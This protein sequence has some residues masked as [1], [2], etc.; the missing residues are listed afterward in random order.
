LPGAATQVYVIYYD[1]EAFDKAPGTIVGSVEAHNGELSLDTLERL[2]QGKIPWGQP[3]VVGLRQGYVT[4]P[5]RA[6]AWVNTVPEEARKKFEAVYNRILNG[7][8][9]L[10]VP[11][12]VLDKI[13]NASVSQ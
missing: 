6:P 2:A 12:A 1:V 4:V 5:L 9:S 10:P 3:E 11:Q 8:L 13:H 7:E